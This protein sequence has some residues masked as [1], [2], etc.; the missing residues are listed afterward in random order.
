MSELMPLS[1]CTR[2]CTRIATLPTG[3]AL[4]LLVPV[5]RPRPADRLRGR[6][7]CKSGRR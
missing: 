2:S 4:A 3:M 6:P 1:S 5:V 7:A